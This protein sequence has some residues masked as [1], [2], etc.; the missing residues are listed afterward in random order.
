[1]ED[2]I[3]TNK[4]LADIIALGLDRTSLSAWPLVTPPVCAAELENLRSDEQADA[5]EIADFAG[6]RRGIRTTWGFVTAT[7]DDDDLKSLKIHIES[8]P[9]F[10]DSNS[11]SGIYLSDIVQVDLERAIEADLE[12][13]SAAG[14]EWTDIG[15]VYVAGELYI[16]DGASLSRIAASL[17][18]VFR[19]IDIAALIS[20]AKDGVANAGK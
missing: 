18:S 4:E 3:Y 20:R 8:D 14:A 9:W 16:L 1:M 19:R 17:A 2:R 7:M 10:A 12:A 5:K 15:S 13:L 6:T 11:N